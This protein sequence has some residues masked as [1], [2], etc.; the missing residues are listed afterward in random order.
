MHDRAA[1]YGPSRQRDRPTDRPTGDISF[2]INVYSNE[3][4]AGR[5]PLS[6]LLAAVRRPPDGWILQKQFHACY[7]VA[8]AAAAPFKG[9]SW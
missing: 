2:L 8:D 7:E 5:R 6:R 1:E 3:P 4:P 9:G